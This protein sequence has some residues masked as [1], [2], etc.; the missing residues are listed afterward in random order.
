VP[1]GAPAHF[2]LLQIRPLVLSREEDELDLGS[3]DAKSLV[4]QSDKALGHGA[5]KD[6]YD[7]V[8]VDRGGFERSKS[9]QVA[10]EVSELNRKLV[11]E[12]RP[13]VLIGVGRWGSLDP[14]LGIPV[15]WDQIAGARV[16]VEAGFKDFDVTPSQGT[17]FFQNINSF[18]VGYFTISSDEHDGF[19]D[20]DWLAAQPAEEHRIFTRHIRL[21]SPMEVKINGQHNRGMICKPRPASDE[22]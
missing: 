12:R 1:P 13:Y 14:W 3:V 17:H 5:L 9:Q 11:A 22:S 4:C 20:W 10:I 16:I 19:V 18:Q 15:K 21:S 7:I 6:L 8:V 2:G